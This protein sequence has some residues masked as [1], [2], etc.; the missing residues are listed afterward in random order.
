MKLFQAAIIL[1]QKGLPYTRGM[2]AGEFRLRLGVI[3][4]RKH[5]RK[6][7]EQKR[8]EYPTPKFDIFA[9]TLYWLVRLFLLVWDR[10]NR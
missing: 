8:G 10:K 7:K 9:S 1:N 3:A 5:K 4:M 6:P 2:Y